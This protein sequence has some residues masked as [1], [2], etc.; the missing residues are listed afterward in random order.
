MSIIK[1]DLGLIG[2]TGYDT[3]VLLEN[4]TFEDGEPSYTVTGNYSKAILCIERKSQTTAVQPNLEVTVG[5]YVETISPLVDTQ[6]S[7]GN[8]S[9][10]TSVSKLVKVHRTNASTYGITAV[11]TITLYLLK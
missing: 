2:G 7:I 9:F 1:E 10:D 8:Y 4:K 3:E 6:H 5:D 11:Y